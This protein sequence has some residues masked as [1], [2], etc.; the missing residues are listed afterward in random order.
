LQRDAARLA[1]AEAMRR[2]CV[3]MLAMAV[4]ASGLLAMGSGLVAPAADTS[5][6]ADGTLHRLWPALDGTYLARLAG[7]AG[8]AN[9]VQLFAAVRDLTFGPDSAAYLAVDPATTE[10]RVIQYHAPGRS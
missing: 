8:P 1:P 4:L 6:P 5:L 10:P 2:A 7:D 3:L 9:V